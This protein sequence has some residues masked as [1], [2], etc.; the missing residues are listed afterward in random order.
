[1]TSTLLPAVRWTKQPFP[2]WSS[3]HPVSSTDSP[4][5]GQSITQPCAHPV[6]LL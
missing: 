4:L 1:M 5:A 6:P 2:R 3:G